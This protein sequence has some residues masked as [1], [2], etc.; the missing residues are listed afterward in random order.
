[1]SIVRSIGVLS[2]RG[3]IRIARRGEGNVV[4]GRG[5]I[6]ISFTVPYV[7]VRRF[8]LLY[9]GDKSDKKHSSQM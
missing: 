9:K 1:M 4:K 2:A 7:T 8:S 6:G 5:L 3:F